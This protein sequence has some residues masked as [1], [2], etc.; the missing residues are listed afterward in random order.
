MTK[1]ILTFLLCVCCLFAEKTPATE[2][3]NRKVIVFDFGGVIAQ[4]NTSQMADFLINS[5]NINKDELS[6]ALSDMQKFLTCGGSEKQFWEQYAISK[7]VSLTNNWFEQFGLVIKNS[8]TEIPETLAIVK[9]LQNHGY[10]T[11]MLSDVTPYQAEIIRKLG[12]YA[13]F[14]PVLLSCEI[15]VKKP[16]LEAFKALLQK[17]QVQAPNVLFIDDRKENVEAAKNL[18]IDSI[19]FINSEQLK[20]ELEKRGYEISS[21]F[22]KMRDN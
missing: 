6:Q 22:I 18:G 2:K 21:L 17:L 10:Q 16:N 15:G 20:K 12:Y 3:T 19:Q 8:I 14:D 9:A 5:F 13:L 1:K 11:A 4:A 7:G